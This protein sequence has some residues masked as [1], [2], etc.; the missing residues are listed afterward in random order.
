[1]NYLIH[2][3]LDSSAK[4]CPDKEAIVHGRER[5]SYSRL[6][7]LSNRFA[8]AFLGLGLRR[9]D[10]VAVLLEKD[11]YQVVSILATSKAG[12]VFVPINH[13]LFP[14]Q[15]K[16]ILNDCKVKGIVASQGKLAS[17]GDV[18]AEIPSLR[19]AVL[20]EEPS[21]SEHPV[22]QTLGIPSILQS[23][24]PEAPSN[25]CISGD[26]ASILYTSGST[27]RPKGVVLTHANLMAG[28]RIVS[29]YLKITE[30]ERILSILP[31]NFDYGLNQLITALQ[32]GATLALLTFRFPDEIVQALIK[33]RITALAGVP[34]LWSLITQPSSSFHR[35]EFPD[36]GYVTNSGGALP[37]TV[38]EALKKALPKARIYLMYGLT[39]AF[40]STYL[41]PEELDRRPASMG[42]AIPD[43]EIFVVNE[44]NELCKPGEPGE[45]VHRGPT[46]SLGYWGQ[47]ETTDLALRPNPFV[48]P[49]LQLTERVC[50][51]GDIV[52]MDD[53]GFL[54]FIGRRDATI[55]SSGY[56]ISPTEV[57]EVIYATGWVREAAAI[58]VA[59]EVLGQYI[60]VFVALNKTDIS[61]EDILIHCA[62]KMPRYMIPKEIEILPELPKT[63]SGKINYP[64]LKALQTQKKEDK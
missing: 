42:R 46:V 51:S 36:L 63:S 6:S 64:A 11:V 48:S 23:Q 26:I 19:F 10:R 18:R 55:K 44:H 39:E 56:R 14:D 41:P 7:A 29:K 15:I 49:E 47:P 54:Y 38:V 57:E 50:Y 27:G 13:L 52:R 62:R 28:S 53:E 59:D 16:H 8:N 12:G 1:M 31:F 30:N 32:N 22:L 35:Y 2:H 5:V 25:K 34:P 33:E 45:L 17:L 21:G 37:I 43:T 20:P 9:G 40:R 3:F 4:S 61:A 60:R 24:S 58:G